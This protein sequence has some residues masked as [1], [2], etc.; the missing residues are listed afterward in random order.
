LT[1]QAKLARESL[2]QQA[3]NLREQIAEQARIAQQSL[4]EQARQAQLARDEIAQPN[5]IIF[6]EP[7]ESDWQILEIIIRNFGNTPAYAVSVILDSPLQSL[8]N[9][10]SNGENYDIPI[11]VEIPTLVPGQQ[12]TTIWDSAVERREKRRLLRTQ[13]IQGYPGGPPTGTDIDTEIETLMPRSRHNA[14]VQYA[15]SKG[16]MHQTQSFSDFNMLDGSMR[17]KTYGIHDIAKKYV[18]DD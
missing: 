7:L 15:D 17:A 5:V 10:I 9:N 13:V 2:E 4:D 14:T 12:W 8:P 1:L 18:N 3:S 16:K 11:P 6:A